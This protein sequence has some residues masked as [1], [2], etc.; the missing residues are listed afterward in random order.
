MA[1]EWVNDSNRTKAGEAAKG[2]AT[3]RDIR[4]ILLRQKA[5]Y[6]RL[7]SFGANNLPEL[8]GVNNHGRDKTL[9]ETI[10]DNIGSVSAPMDVRFTQVLS[11]TISNK[12]RESDT[13]VGTHMLFSNQALAD[14][15]GAGSAREESKGGGQVAEMYALF[16]HLAV[17][18]AGDGLGGVCGRRRSGESLSIH[19]I[20][21]G[22]NLKVIHLRRILSWA[23][24]WQSSGLERLVSQIVNGG[25]VEAGRSCRRV[26]RDHWAARMQ[27]DIATPLLFSSSGLLHLQ[28]VNATYQKLILRMLTC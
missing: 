20:H 27:P 26:L 28:L 12:V 25:I 2:M 19:E 3:F 8:G 6:L 11:G 21:A 18:A 10:P 13:K 22:H 7:Q 5:L 15:V 1:Y 23:A 9:L 17:T 16:A 24:D 4:D 14:E